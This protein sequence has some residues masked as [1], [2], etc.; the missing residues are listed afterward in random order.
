[1]KYLTTFILCFV[2]LSVSAQD[3]T[4]RDFKKNT[5]N[6]LA[7]TNPVLDRNGDE[8]AVIRFFVPQKDFIIIPNLGSLKTVRQ[9]G[10]I[11]VYVPQGTKRITV[12]KSNLL[13]LVDY[14]IPVRIEK[15]TTYDATLTLTDEGWKHLDEG[16]KA[17][18]SHSVYVGLGYNV[19]SIAGPSVALG[20]DFH[21]NNIELNFVPG[22][23]KSDDIYF[24]NTDQTLRSAYNYKAMRISLR[25][26]YDIPCTDFLTITPQVGAT[27]NYIHG[28]K[29]GSTA[30]T[31]DYMKN[32]SSVSGLVAVHLIAALNNTWRLQVTPEYNFGISKNDDCKTLNDADD[33]IKSWTEGFNLNLG[34]MIFF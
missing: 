30:R 33:K 8:C 25:Y 13:P 3:I 21:H 6:L 22:L 14:E 26:G 20:F 5:T 7:R 2:T 29:V 12:S 28:S 31:E 4:I 24:Y 11:A 9:T 10:M 18:R 17:N 19:V 1:M 32:A 34:L 16:T 23:N 15:K 27:Y